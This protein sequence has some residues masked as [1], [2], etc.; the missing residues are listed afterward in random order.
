MNKLVF[1]SLSILL[2]FYSS[3]LAFCNIIDSTETDNYYFISDRESIDKSL[4]MYK[5]RTN[6]SGISS[7]LI[8]GNFEIANYPNMRKA[9]ISVYN[10]S[11]DQLVGIYNTHPTTGNYIAILLPNVKYEFVINTYGYA[12]IKKVVEIPN[13]ASTDISDE[14]STQKML[15]N[16]DSGEVKLS[17]NT[18]FVE[19]KEPTLFLLTVYN[20][21][22][23]DKHKVELYQ[24]T[25]EEQIDYDRKMLSESDF[26]NID[27]LLK[28][29]AEAESKKPAQAEKAFNKKDYK[30][31]INIYSQLLLLNEDEPIYNYRKG[32]ALYHTEINKLKA[33]PFLKKA[34]GKADIPYNIHLLLGT[35]YHQWSDFANAHE[36]YKKYQAKASANELKENEVTKLIK[37][38]ENGKRIISDQYDMSVIHKEVI[39]LNKITKSLPQ[40]LVSDKLSYKTE[41]FI[42]P[43]DAKKKQK[44][45]MFKT[46]FNEMIQTSYGMNEANGLDLYYNTLLGGDKWSTSKTLGENINTPEDENYAYVTPDGLTLYFAS[47]GHNSIGGYDIFESKRSNTNEAWGA[48]KNMGYPIN[49]AFDDFMFMPSENEEEAY[50]ISNRR[51]PSGGFNLY[52]IKM[53][54]PALALSIVKG[55]FMTNDSIPNFS[56]SI[57]VYNT[58]NQEIVGIYNTNI[59]NGNFLMALIPGIKYE[60]AVSADGFNEHLAYVT[61]PS[62]TDPFPLR[63]N[64]RLKK[65]GSFEILNVDNYFTREEAETAPSYTLTADDFKTEAPTKPK[66]ELHPIEKQFLGPNSAQRELL[67]SAEQLFTNKQYLKCVQK[68]EK[69]APLVKLSDKQAYYYGKSLFSVT[70]EY[71]R[72][73]K[74]LE[75]AANNKSTPYDVYF[76][77]GQTN[78]NAYRFER[79]V[80][81][82]EK[83]KGYANEKEQKSHD[84]EQLITLSK[85]G[86]DII[87]SPKPIEVISK[88]SVKQQLL[89]TAYGSLDINAKFLLAPDDMVSAKDKKEGFQP[90]MYLNKKKTAIYFASYGENGE[91]GKDIFLMKKLPNNT[92]SEPINLGGVVNSLGDEDYPFLTED[93]KTLYFCS[94]QHGS[95]GGYDIFKSTW[96]EQNQTWGYPTNLGAP[97][98]SPFNDFFYVEE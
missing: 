2:Y 38:C 85:F 5:A 77:L 86:K 96:D 25:S 36:S 26:G 71:D 57:A 48:P 9:E 69:V 22:I 50:F 91:N 30:T 70:R 61:I 72:T 98:N 10:I 92:W 56:A 34:V 35:I 28:K 18:L 53:P 8:K 17:L 80:N 4:F 44:Q 43:T 6:A 58:N 27:E 23:E 62:Q 54:K 66:D 32:V 60:F 40:V 21:D 46:D 42:S 67:A 88:K 37:N 76:M 52:Q 84:L 24:A 51:S 39:E 45:L 20:E 94:T 82:Y 75:Q 59:N 65:E 68:F 55:H 81:A 11:N 83:Y 95:M 41:F 12:P 78:H 90:V 89:H 47:K 73:L 93:G 15:L 87:N 7:C 97:I 63:Q 29:E 14:V 33:L 19:E 13:Y 1:T 31:A 79:A 64:I 16:V 49:S 3:S 74:Y